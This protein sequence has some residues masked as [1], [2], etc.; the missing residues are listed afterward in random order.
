MK[1]IDKMR[2]LVNSNASKEQIIEWAYLNRV[3]LDDLLIEPGFEEMQESIM[4]FFDKNW[5]V[6]EDEREVWNKFLDSEFVERR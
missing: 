5:L 2:E 3:W 6:D 1:N 4:H